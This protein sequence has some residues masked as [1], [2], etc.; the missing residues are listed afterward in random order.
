[1]DPLG[2]EPGKFLTTK[3]RKYTQCSLPAQRSTQKVNFDKFVNLA[4]QG[5][6]RFTRYIARHTNVVTG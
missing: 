4:S 6:T 2:F 1:M 3:Q 5:I